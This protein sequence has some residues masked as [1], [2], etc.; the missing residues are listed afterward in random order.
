[1]FNYYFNYSFSYWFDWLYPKISMVDYM[2]LG[3][4]GGVLAILSDLL[5]SFLKRS[6]GV[7]VSKSFLI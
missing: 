4:V 5:E 6:A 7:K 3:A 2:I 1:M